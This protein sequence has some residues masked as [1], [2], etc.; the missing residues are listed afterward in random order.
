MV[1]DD[2]LYNWEDIED[3]ICDR[4]STRLIPTF[5]SH[6]TDKN[7]L[8]LNKGHIKQ[9]PETLAM[10]NLVPTKTSSAVIHNDVILNKPSE[11]N[12]HSFSFRAK[13]GNNLVQSPNEPLLLNPKKKEEHKKLPR[14]KSY[15]IVSCYFGCYAGL[16][17]R[18]FTLICMLLALSQS[19]IH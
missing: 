4:T 18:N 6:Q 17:F 5:W 11:K 15:N 16:Q 14:P 10:V 9:Q 3:G 1:E 7:L 8:L 2:D 19:M 13:D 12:T